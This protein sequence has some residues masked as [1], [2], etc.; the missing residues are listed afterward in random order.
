M[1]GYWAHSAGRVPIYVGIG[2]HQCSLLGAGLVE[3]HTL[4]INLGTGAQVSTLEDKWT[5]QEAETRPYFSGQML[6]T[7]T[8]IPGG[9]ALAERC[10][11]PSARREADGGGGGTTPASKSKQGASLG[12]N[13]K[14]DVVCEK[15][16]ALLIQRTRPTPAH[17]A[18][19]L[20]Q[21]GSYKLARLP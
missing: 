17:T 6:N 5:P 8:H 9:R 18:D 7:I 3:R 12:P 16:K 19:A 21:E 4:S 1:A 13:A 10:A 11:L 15:G 14:T 20:F 2:D